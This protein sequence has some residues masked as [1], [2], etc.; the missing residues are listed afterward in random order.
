MKWLIILWPVHVH[1]PDKNRKVSGAADGH[2]FQVASLVYWKGRT[3]KWWPCWSSFHSSIA[4][5]DLSWDGFVDMIVPL[6]RYS[7]ACKICKMDGHLSLWSTSLWGQDFSMFSLK[8]Q[9]LETIKQLYTTL[10]VTS[11]W[12]FRHHIDL[13]CRHLAMLIGP[14]MVLLAP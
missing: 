8:Q 14:M 2:L 7:I 10:L 3:L 1:W 4:V 9:V 11:Y 12:L 6:W 5:I 13:L